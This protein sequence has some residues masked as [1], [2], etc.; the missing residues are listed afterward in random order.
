MGVGVAVADKDPGAATDT[1][2]MSVVGGGSTHQD[3]MALGKIVDLP[4]YSKLDEFNTYTEM[5]FD[6]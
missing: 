2:C 6:D 5:I 1:R 3:A 4:I